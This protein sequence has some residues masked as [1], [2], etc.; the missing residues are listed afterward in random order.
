MLCKCATRSGDFAF[1]ICL[2]RHCVKCQAVM[3]SNAL[4]L[5]LLPKRVSACVYISFFYVKRHK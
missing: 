2:H 1:D 3:D 5:I 4:I